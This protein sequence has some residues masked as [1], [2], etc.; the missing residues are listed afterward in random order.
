M[1]GMNNGWYQ[2]N[3]GYS[4]D[5]GTPTAGNGVFTTF[6]EN[7]ETVKNYLVPAGGMAILINLNGGKM[8]FKSVNTNG[9]PAPIR[10]FNI[11]EIPLPIPAGANVVTRA[12]FDT[13]KQQL[14]QITQL[15]QNSLQGTAGTGGNAK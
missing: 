1:N 2:P 3:N 13:M 5:Q 10:T 14:N 7:E 8:Y 15:L 12:E 9:V 6:I 4:R 11:K